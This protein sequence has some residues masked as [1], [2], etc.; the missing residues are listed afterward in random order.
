MR[1]DRAVR[2]LA[3]CL[4]F[5]LSAG[6]SC[7]P[8]FGEPEWGENPFIADRDRQAPAAAPKAPEEEKILLQGILWDPLAPTAIV[9]NRV[10]ARGDRV[11]RWEVREIQK[12]RVVLSDGSETR[13]LRAE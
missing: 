12:D 13:T 5:V 9:S 7:A 8:V 2:I 10:V 6:G 11:G 3:G 1:S 4:G